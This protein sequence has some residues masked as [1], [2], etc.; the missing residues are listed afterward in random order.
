MVGCLVGCLRCASISTGE[1]NLGF[2]GSLSFFLIRD[3][4]D[5]NACIHLDAWWL[6]APLLSVLS[7]AKV[8][9]C[10]HFLHIEK[11]TVCHIIWWKKRVS[12]KIYANSRI[13][14][15]SFCIDF[16]AHSPLL[17][18]TIFYFTLSFSRG[19]KHSIDTF[20]LSTFLSISLIHFIPSPLDSSTDSCKSMYWTMPTT[21]GS[22]APSRPS[23]DFE[24]GSS[25]PYLRLTGLRSMLD[26][27]R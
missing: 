8:D 3:G 13:F 23:T 2:W 14:Y 9:G 12:S 6:P 16:G 26:L 18:R 15:S 20:Y 22:L 11:E 19:R 27:D 17:R 4:Q 1:G 7:C 24:S 21:S 25:L 10:A 5:A